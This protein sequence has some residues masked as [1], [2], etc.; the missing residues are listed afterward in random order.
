MPLFPALAF[1]RLI[2]AVTDFPFVRLQVWQLHAIAILAREVCVFDVQKRS[3]ASLLHLLPLAAPP[4]PD[5]VSVVVQCHMQRIGT[6]FPF[7]RFQAGGN[8]MYMFTWQPI[9]TAPKRQNLRL[10]VVNTS[11]EEYSL[12]FPCVRTELGFVTPKGTVLQVTPTHW[13]DFVHRTA[14]LNPRYSPPPAPI[15]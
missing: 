10:R 12:T 11:G 8:S 5:I 4:F 2:F 1:S 7:R 13:M 15:T 3:V 6:D 9:E 14:R